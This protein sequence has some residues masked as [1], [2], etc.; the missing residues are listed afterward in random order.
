MSREKEKEITKTETLNLA[1][2]WAHVVGYASVTSAR[3]SGA[4]PAPALAFSAS[5]TEISFATE[6]APSEE[7]EEEERLRAWT[8]AGRVEAVEGGGR[9][10]AESPRPEV[11]ATNAC[12][13]FTAPR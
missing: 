1:S 3:N 4:T 10:A 12:P 13:A 6:I 2:S 8:F 7:D 11:I 9:G 5:N